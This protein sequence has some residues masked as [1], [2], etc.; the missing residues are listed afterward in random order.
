VLIQTTDPDHPVMQALADGDRER[1]IAAEAG[2]R[3]RA[4]LPPYGRL[5]ALILSAPDQRVVDAV[6]GELA[7]A[8]P[9]G[10]GV[11][12]LGPAPAPLA[13]L[14]G[15]H[16]RRFLLRTGRGQPI[17]AHIR[18][19]LAGRRFPA[20]LRLQIDVDPQSFL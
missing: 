8:A 3:K 9:G 12:V 20:Q 15:R 11:E 2:G 18:K 7:R 14:R 10:D 16:R 4:G 5:A 17:Q 13:I 6:A 19:W 1:F